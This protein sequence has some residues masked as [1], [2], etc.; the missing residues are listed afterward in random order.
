MIDYTVDS[1]VWISSFSDFDGSDP[2]SLSP[3]L[4][5]CISNTS[6]I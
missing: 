3:V 2:L 5:K 6:T 1:G 4:T